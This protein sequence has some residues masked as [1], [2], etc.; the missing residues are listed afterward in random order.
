MENPPK[1]KGAKF[2]VVAR[3][4]HHNKAMILSAATFGVAS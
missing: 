2:T 4:V 1:K 3:A